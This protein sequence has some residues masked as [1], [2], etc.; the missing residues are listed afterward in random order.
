MLAHINRMIK[1]KCNMY[2]NGFDQRIARQQ[3]CKTQY[4]TQQQRDCFLW[5]PRHNHCYAMAQ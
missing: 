2:C 5:G 1:Y 4:I 3:L